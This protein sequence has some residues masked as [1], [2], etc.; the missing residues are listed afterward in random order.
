MLRFGQSSGQDNVFFQLRYEPA[1]VGTGILKKWISF[2]LKE[3]DS[4][5]LSPSLELF[6]P[7]LVVPR[8]MTANPYSIHM[9]KT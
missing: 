3:D 9:A 6:T 7:R 1:S 8:D 5:S 2:I 4:K